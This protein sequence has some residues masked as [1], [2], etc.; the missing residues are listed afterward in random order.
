MRRWLAWNV[1]FRLQEAVKGHPTYRIL[2]EMEAADRLPA[3]DLE[4]LVNSRLV[5]FIGFCYANVPYVRDTLDSLGLGPDAI[6][7]PQDLRL[8]PL[9]R[10]AEVRAHR[11]ALRARGAGKLGQ[12]ATGGSTGEPLIFDIGPR[13]TASRIACRQRVSRWW[14][15]SLGDPELAFWGSPIELTRQDKIRNWRDKLL[16]TR[17][18][19]AF[20]MNEATMSRY[21]DILEQGPCRQI[22]GYPSAI[23]ALCRE[24]QREGRNLRETGVRTVFVTGEVLLPFQRELISETLNC[25]VADGYGGRDSGFIAHE[26][27]QG[28]MHILADTVIVEL[29]DD[30]GQPVAPGQPGEIV[31]TDLYSH[32]FPFL[33]YATGDM[34]VATER[35]CRCGRA[36][37]LLE[38]IE[39]R[40]NDSV[41]APD[42]RLINAL[43]VVYAVREV[44]GIE[45][46][47]IRQTRVDAFTVE[48][49]RGADYP[50]DAEQR[51]RTAWSVLLRCPVE[52]EF[53]YPEALTPDKSGKFRHVVSELAAG[54]A[55]R[56]V[57]A[58]AR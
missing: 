53:R 5:E 32:E 19:S 16:A 33:R 37:P 12:L 23:Y 39:G 22:F 43:A 27:P 50:V 41:V 11:E 14:G 54:S 42:G 24:A 18:L 40:L 15:L 13:R 29:L 48:I 46:F 44:A 55:L 49:V 17:L 25:P 1:F 28:G 51:I 45:K 9:M 20:E 57:A 36:L 34:A 35:R 52:V 58:E 7:C 26:C 56:A 8:L 6:R 38:R 10:K 31:V 2:R 30:A 4:A 47:R 21:L 3:A